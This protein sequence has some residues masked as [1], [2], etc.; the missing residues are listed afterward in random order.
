[1]VQ[2]M[3]KNTDLIKKAETYLGDGGSRFR[4]YCGLPA[5]AAWCNAFVT[6]I[7]Y[8]TGNKKLYCNG[9]KETYCPHSIEWCYKNFALLPLYMALPGDV[10]YFDWQPNGTPD[11][12]GFVKE[13]I[14]DQKIGTIEG[15]TTN[16]GIVAKRVRT[17]AEVQ[18]VF[19]IQYPA[20][21]KIGALKVDGEFG[22]SSIAMMQ[23]V[24]G[25]KV[26]G[27]MGQETV[28]AWQDLVGVKEDGWWGPK[29]SKAT[30]ELIGVKTDGWFGPKSVKALQKWINRHSIGALANYYAYTTNTK[31]ADYGTGSP[32][33]EYK[34]ALN[35]A[36]PDRDS[37]GTG[38]RKG[39]S[40]D[41]FVGTCV[42]SSGVDPEFPRG[43][44]EQILYLAKSGKFKQVNVTV[45]SAKDG[46]IIVYTKQGGGAHICI[47]YDGKIKEA[48][49]DMYY[50]KTTPYL[51]QRLSTAKK[52]WVRVYRVR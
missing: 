24:L 27:I 36:Y 33:D 51:K 25:I 21:F 11:H 32:K 17:E 18:G 3:G 28:K 40:C 22:Y 44:K 7:F 38:A 23:L 31:K 39:A 42:R 14:T 8:I 52:H 37:W 48:S 29:T 2:T 26:D 19:R 45:S 4:R 47:V 12:I 46:D 13:R 43:L 10:I 9:A 1:M 16:E 49:H 5:G 6:Y 50:P 30:Q 34:S 35:K 20:E 41:V 15:N